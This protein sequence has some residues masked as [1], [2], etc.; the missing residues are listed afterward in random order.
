M[1]EEYIHYKYNESYFIAN[2][3][4]TNNIIRRRD[5][6]NSENQFEKARCLIQCLKYFAKIDVTTITDLNEH[7]ECIGKSPDHETR[8]CCSQHEEEGLN[9]YII[10]HK[11]TQLSFVIGR[12]CFTN[13]FNN[14]PPEQFNKFYQPNCDYCEQKIKVYNKNRP[15]FCNQKCVKKHR[16]Q[17]ERKKM[18]EAN[19]K[20]ADEAPLREAARLKKWEEEAPLRE[21]KAKKWEEE[22]K[23][24]M[25]ANQ[26][27]IESQQSK[28]KKIVY[29]HCLG[30]NKPKTCENH[31]KWPLCYKCNEK[32]KSLNQ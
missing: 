18:E 22:N 8:C 3:F 2:Y 29:T 5:I 7:F 30:C 1:T 6:S 32:K 4:N 17:E 20:W 16:E 19:K 10:V 14:V 13:L 9:S 23:R 12:V 21:E 27:Y 31:Q 24:I 11:V 28:N 25:E 15:N 26:K